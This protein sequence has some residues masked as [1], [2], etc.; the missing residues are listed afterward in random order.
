MGV[1]GAVALPHALEMRAQAAV[2]SMVSV[3]RE[4]TRGAP[5]S[6]GKVRLEVPQLADNG[7]LVPLRV[8]VDSPMTEE[9]HVRGIV[10]VAEKN[11]RPVVARFSFGPRAGRAGVATRIRLAGSQRVVAIAEMSDGS[12][13]T[14]LA[15]VTVTLAAC[16]EDA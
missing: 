16:I 3:L 7:N 8:T 13:W 4:V 5:T 9:K 12:F 6:P 1:A 10:L 14:D 11:P 15:E 2:E